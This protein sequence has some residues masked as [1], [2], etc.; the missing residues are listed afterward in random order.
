MELRGS[1]QQRDAIV[2][3]TQLQLDEAHK[4]LRDMARL[5]AA[6]VQRLS[7]TPSLSSLPVAPVCLTS[8]R[9]R[10]NQC[11]CCPAV[12]ACIHQQGAAG[13]GAAAVALVARAAVTVVHRGATTVANECMEGVPSAA[14]GGEAQS[15][16]AHAAS[17]LHNCE[18]CCSDRRRVVH[19]RQRR[20]T[21]RCT[22]VRVYDSEQS[23]TTRWGIHNVERWYRSH[24]RPCRRRR[25][26]LGALLCGGRR[27]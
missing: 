4:G 1:E 26:Y 18:A 14:R 11:P 6:Y 15:H 22:E 27:I 3:A 12:S 7:I 16:A 24:R 25:R 10:V 17:R 19:Q 21:P 5:L 13:A 9:I 20:V 2:S 8:Y 23:R